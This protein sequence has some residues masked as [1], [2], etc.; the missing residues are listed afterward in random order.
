MK[1]DALMKGLKLGQK[2][3]EYPVWLNRNDEAALRHKL[4]E[5]GHIDHEGQE[6][7]VMSFQG[8]DVRFLSS[9]K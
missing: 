4:F 6:L 1:I 8:R 7:P 3:H 9:L 5:L 2:G